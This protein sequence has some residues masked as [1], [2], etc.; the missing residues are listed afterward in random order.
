MGYAISWPLVK[1]LSRTDYQHR[2]YTE[3]ARVSELLYPLDQ[4]ID[5]VYRFDMGHNMADWN[6]I[7]TTENTVALHW[8]KE[9]DLVSYNHDRLVEAWERAGRE[10]S[11]R[12]GV[13]LDTLLMSGETRVPPTNCSGWYDQWCDRPEPTEDELASMQ[14]G[15][16]QKAEMSTG[17]QP[18]VQPTP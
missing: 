2:L 8:I 1:Y 7:N 18:G 3:D 14:H 17:V 6:Q 12:N 15:R 5:R 9:D 10:W 4:N 16:S 13:P 11:N